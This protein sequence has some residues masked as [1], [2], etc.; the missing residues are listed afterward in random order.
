VSIPL[1]VSG[2]FAKALHR[3][4]QWLRTNTSWRTSGT[5]AKYG[6]LDRAKIHPGL[7]TDNEDSYS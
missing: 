5:L 1:A 6:K 3:H 2:G 7:E 4:L